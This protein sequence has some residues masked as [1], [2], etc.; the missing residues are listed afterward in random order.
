MEL[1]VERDPPSGQ[2]MDVNLFELQD[3]WYVD[4]NLFELQD[5]ISALKYERR[6]PSRADDRG[7]AK[8]GEDARNWTASHSS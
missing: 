4:V 2:C 1:P 6:S 7:A 5:C 3:K 8:A